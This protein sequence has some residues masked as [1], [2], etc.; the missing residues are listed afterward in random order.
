MGSLRCTIGDRTPFDEDEHHASYDR[1]KVE[2]FHRILLQVDDLFKEFR[3]LYI[4]KS[5]P[6]HFF[7]V[8]FDLAVT[9]FSGRLNPAP[10][11]SKMM[12]EAYSH[13]V[14]SCGFWPGDRRYPEP[15]FYSY[16]LPA[17]A[18]FAEQRAQPEK[19]Y[20]DTKLGEF[21]LR[22]DDVRSD[23]KPRQGVL[24]FCQ[25][26]YGIAADLG[27][28]DRAALERPASSGKAKG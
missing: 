10:A 13:E 25:S 14:S 6:V 21:L 8:S 27:K 22:Y 7:W 5:S 24:D 12:R 28:W 9:R 3:S 15:A 2:D 19:A 20:W 1:A 26:T 18:G 23:A 4:G 17:P 16:A 11:G